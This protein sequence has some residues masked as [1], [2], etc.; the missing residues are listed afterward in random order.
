MPTTALMEAY[1]SE[2][3]PC[4]ELDDLVAQVGDPTLRRRIQNAIPRA[5]AAQGRA[6]MEHRRHVMQTL[7]N[8]IEMV[9]GRNR[10]GRSYMVGRRS[11]KEFLRALKIE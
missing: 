9:R 5:Y 11:S 8:A 7:H 1:R 3:S 2:G 10:N 4:E 6:S